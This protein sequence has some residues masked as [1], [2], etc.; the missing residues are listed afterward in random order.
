VIDYR[1]WRPL[2][3]ALLLSFS[4]WLAY[5][6]G[7][8][9]GLPTDIARRYLDYVTREEYDRALALADSL[10]EATPDHPGGWLLRAIIYNN[11]SI[12]FEDS[13]ERAALFAAC[14]SVTTIAL[15]RIA[16]GD[17]AGSNWFYLGTAE[18]FR[19]LV[20]LRG[21]RNIDA[22][23]AGSRAAT[24]LET[25]LARDPSCA[26][27]CVGL[28][29]YYYFKSK[30][31]GIL[32]SLGLVA[33]RRQDGIAMLERGA[34]EGVLTDLAAQSSLAWIAIDKGDYHRADSIAASLLDRYPENRAF[35]WARGAAR[36]RMEDWDSTLAIYNRI[37]TSVRRQARNNHLN[38]VS[39]LNSIATAYSK[40]GK[41]ADAQ[42]AAS[43]ALAL[44]LS[45]SV[46]DRKAKDLKNLRSIQA[47]A[48]EHFE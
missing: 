38:E 37:L 24:H 33:D 15:R 29:N 12:D 21:G 17:S 2:A 30:Y 23:L 36:R 8:G 44:P 19:L 40:Q 34:R 3:A 20:A 28:G 25:A 26:D 13:S 32:R 27:A 9:T 11:R 16:A 45:K 18:G 42:R 39:C 31:S 35:L 7:N 46:R 14:D 22:I 47:E 41:W 5:T 1:G 4:G 6:Y 48:E 43:E 10:V